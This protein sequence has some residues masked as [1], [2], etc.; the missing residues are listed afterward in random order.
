MCDNPLNPFH[1]DVDCKCG[2]LDLK[3]EILLCALGAPCHRISGSWDIEVF[4]PILTEGEV[5][6]TGARAFQF[7]HMH[8]LLLF[9]L[10]GI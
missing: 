10:T 6:S 5:P 7:L 4:F 8:F 1:P 3:R 9:A 2:Y